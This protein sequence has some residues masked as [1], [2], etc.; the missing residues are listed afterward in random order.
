MAATTGRP[1]S[2]MASDTQKITAPLD[3]GAG[4]VN[5]INDENPARGARL[6]PAFFRQP[7][8]VRPG[9]QK[10]VLQE[11]ISGH[12]GRADRV[13]GPLFPVLQ[14]RA[15]TKI[16]HDQMAR[17]A[18]CAGQKIEVAA[19]ARQRKARPRSRWAS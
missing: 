2:T 9:D 17:I 13:A 5:R 18:R 6:G 11:G 8:I 7:A 4:A 3:K 19:S 12:I 10:R 1:F 15:F 14:A 16:V